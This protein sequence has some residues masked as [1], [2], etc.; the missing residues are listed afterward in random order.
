[1]LFFRIR[2]NAILIYQ[3]KKFTKHLPFAP[4]LFIT[5]ICIKKNVKIYSIA[6]R[7]LFHMKKVGHFSMRL[8]IS[9][10]LMRGLNAL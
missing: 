8:V 3:F 10:N 2:Q 9:P 1:M 4:A 6:Q 7:L 5:S